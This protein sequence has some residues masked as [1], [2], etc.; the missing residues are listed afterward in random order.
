MDDTR[1]SPV[2]PVGLPCLAEILAREAS[3]DEIDPRQFAE[4]A[5]VGF[6]TNLRK[7]RP[8]HIAGSC[9][10]LAKRGDLV[11]RTTESFFDPANSGK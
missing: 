11:S 10:D 5:H 4:Q 2:D 6:E 9:I 8:E 1:L 7:M 3:S